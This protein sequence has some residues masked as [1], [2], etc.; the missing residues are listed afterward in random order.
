MALTLCHLLADH[1][2]AH[3][4]NLLRLDPLHS[5]FEE[6]SVS[7]VQLPTISLPRAQ[8]QLRF[9]TD[10]RNVVQGIDVDEVI[11]V[12]LLEVI[13]AIGAANEETPII[14]GKRILDEIPLH[15]AR[16]DTVGHLGSSFSCYERGRCSTSLGRGIACRAFC[17]LPRNKP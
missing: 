13:V 9:R 11:A 14:V 12:D 4:P 8:T 3:S 1:L 10:P 6:R 7:P 16:A 5:G 15:T 17:P 2:L